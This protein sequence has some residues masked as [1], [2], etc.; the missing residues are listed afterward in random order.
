ML[1]PY[2]SFNFG[3]TGNSFNEAGCHSTQRRI[4]KE[5]ENSEFAEDSAG[6]KHSI[7]LKA[8]FFCFVLFYFTLC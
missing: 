5:P 1:W 2:V 4:G 8:D 3:L 6:V 7:V